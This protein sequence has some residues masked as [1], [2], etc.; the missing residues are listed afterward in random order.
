MG[1]MS[2]SRIKNLESLCPYQYY[3]EQVTHEWK[4]E[5]S[6]QMQRGNY[7]EY[8][9]IGASLAGDVVELPLA[10]GKP[11]VAQERLDEQAEIFKQWVADNNIEII[12]TQTEIKFENRFKG[13]IDVVLGINKRPWISDLKCT[14]DIINTRSPQYSWHS[15]EYMDVLQA[16]SYLIA[17]QDMHGEPAEGFLYYVVDYTP[18]KKKAIWDV[19]FDLNKKRDEFLTRL[20][21]AEEKHEKILKGELPPDFSMCATCKRKEVCDVR[22][23]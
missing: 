11:S 23:I 6:I 19:K 21:S 13:V 7:F 4:D 15:I 22:K 1:L 8:K 10:R 12:S 20:S 5:P 16:F 18:A 9:A 17:W 14:S 3:K 2:Q